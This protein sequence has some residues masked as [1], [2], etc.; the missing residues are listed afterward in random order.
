[1]EVENRIKMQQEGI[2]LA[3]LEEILNFPLDWGWKWHLRSNKYLYLSRQNFE[4]VY[5]GVVYWDSSTE[6]L[7]TKAVELAL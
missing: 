4:T 3:K 2:R 5:V 7:I 1:M 6:K